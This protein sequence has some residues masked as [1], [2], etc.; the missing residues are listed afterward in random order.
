MNPDGF[1]QLDFSQIYSALNLDILDF[2]RRQKYGKLFL[3]AGRFIE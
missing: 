3:F 1:V 2:N